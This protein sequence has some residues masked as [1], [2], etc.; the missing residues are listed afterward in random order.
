M[1]IARREWLAC[2]VAAAT[3][4]F[5]LPI[6]AIG[7]PKRMHH[8]TDVNKNA[9]QQFIQVVW[10]EGRLEKLADFWTPDCINHAAPEGQQ[11]G[12]E[13]LHAYHGQFA[14]AF[15][16]FSD[17]HIDVKQQVAEADR[18][19]TQMVTTAKHTGTFFGS[20]PT[21]K[22][23]SLATIRIDRLRDGKIVEHWSIADMA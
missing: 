2:S 16:A 5:F 8:V 11:Q 15:A 14:A 3:T 9:V 18:V 22:M 7:A 23:A 21:G 19:V 13:A 4:H 1:K 6:R 10:R 20:P 12:L 17:A